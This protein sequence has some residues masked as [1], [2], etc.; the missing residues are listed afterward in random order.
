LVDVEE[1]KMI[2]SVW[3]QGARRFDYYQDAQRNHRANTP[4]PKHLRATHEIG[5]PVD[6]A[7]WPLPAG[8]K[9][10]G[11]G[12]LPRGRV[13]SRAAL[14]GLGAI[15]VTSP[16]TIAILLGIAALIYWKS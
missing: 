9:K 1:E 13:A 15:D 7:G 10:I 12:P 16:G 8:A 14:G 2:Y 4:S 6:R 11:S 5:I 3:N